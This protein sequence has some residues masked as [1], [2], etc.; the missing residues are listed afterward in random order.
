MASIKRRSDEA[1]FLLE[2]LA[3]LGNTLWLTPTLILY[4]MT[5]RRH[6]ATFSLLA[7]VLLGG[8]IAPLSHFAFMAFSD[9]YAMMDMPAHKLEHESEQ[10][11]VGLEMAMDAHAECP[12]AAFFLSQSPGFEG[13]TVSVE[14]P[15]VCGYSFSLSESTLV[16]VDHLTLSARGPP[17]DSQTIV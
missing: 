16:S 2:T 3:P 15:R 4:F 17:S 11:G 9:S 1:K 6:I 10:R 7:S 8:L 12:F 14:A 13:S 5:I